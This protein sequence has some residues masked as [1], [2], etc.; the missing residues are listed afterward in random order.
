M[1][2]FDELIWTFFSAVIYLLIIVYL[3]FKNIRRDKKTIL[4]LFFLLFTCTAL[5]N[6]YIQSPGVRF[7]VVFVLIIF[8]SVVIYRLN[9]FESIALALMS[10]FIILVT[11][12]VLLWF[13]VNVMVFDITVLSSTLYV[14]IANSLFLLL[15]IIIILIRQFFYRKNSS[16]KI[17]IK[18]FFLICVVFIIV[19]CTLNLSFNNKIINTNPAAVIMF[20]L[21]AFAVY[22]IICLFLI[23]IYTSSSRQQILLDQQTKEYEQLVEY[24]GIIEKLYDNIR[25]QKHDFTNVILS[26]KGY[27][28]KEQYEEL[29]NYYYSSVL[30]EY[31]GK[32]THSFI[33][34]LNLIQNPGIKGIL[35]YKL[36]RAISHGIKVYVNIF[37]K[38]T[39][40]VIG[41]LDLC[42][43]VGILIDNAIEASLES[44]QK[45]IH[46]AIENNDKA[47]SIIIANTYLFEPNIDY[48]FRRG[49]STK[50]KNRGLG[51][52]N[53]NE[54]L[55][56][57]PS[58][59]LKTTVN[60]NTF[61]QELIIPEPQ[62]SPISASGSNF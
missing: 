27:V 9:I 58:V 46:L 57:Y 17:S 31:K 4:F 49:Y 16:Y 41:N 42:K 47:V 20:N 36:N 54:T 3:N 40:Q 30:K 22:F 19:V 2:G 23:L 14:F 53:V 39:I 51:L 7:P 52:F 26:L 15:T 35:S 5:V 8:S 34:S 62:Y 43:I 6:T 38:I 12:S 56:R 10:V 45:E 29:K 37:S 25:N 59:Q 33:C 48:V 11:D 60:N 61:F 32:L 50:G 1:F 24:T 44:V 18:L 28:D 55:S 21:V 13:L